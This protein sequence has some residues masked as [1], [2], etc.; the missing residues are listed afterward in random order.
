MNL[1]SN[2]ER[3]VLKNAQKSLQIDEGVKKRFERAEKA[4]AIGDLQ[5]Q[6][7]GK[8]LNEMV[9]NYK[10]ELEGDE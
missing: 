6:D 7:V 5:N 2:K 8:F 1:L 9:K 10:S 4:E 3:E